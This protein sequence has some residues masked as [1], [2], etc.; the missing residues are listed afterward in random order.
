MTAPAG[1]VA[2]AEQHGQPAHAEPATHEAP[3]KDAHDADHAKVATEKNPAQGHAEA[4]ETPESG[5]FGFF[6]F[7]AFDIL[8][9]GAVVVLDKTILNPDHD[10]E[11]HPSRVS[12][13]RRQRETACRRIFQSGLVQSLRIA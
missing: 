11:S 13:F 2:P 5:G 9:I 6:S 10:E 8:L 3:A 1:H 12:L 7:I 4:A